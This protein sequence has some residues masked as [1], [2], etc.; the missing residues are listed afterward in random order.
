MRCPHCG[1]PVR[2]AQDTCFACGEKLRFRWL[3]REQTLDIRIVILG[4]IMV[5][6]GL[7]GFFAVHL[8]G[9]KTVG[10]DNKKKPLKKLQVVQPSPTKKADTLR[11]AVDKVE[12][13]RAREQLER[14]KKR[15]AA[16]KSQVLGETPTPEQQELM[17]QIDREL[18]IFQR[19]I[20]EYA[21]PITAQQ[22]QLLRKE[23][24][25]QPR[26]INN[27]ISQFSRAPKNR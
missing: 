6:L 1:E 7:S 3:R 21:R 25:A 9:R 17:A 16:V 18:S 22:S 8:A 5:V 11:Q 14:L 26:E 2:A 15:Y 12:V 20:G 23:L 13:E 10:K 24:T 4:I 27:L 19:K